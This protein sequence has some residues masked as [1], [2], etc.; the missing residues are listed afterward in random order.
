[1]T[2]TYTS[3]DGKE[4]QIL[5]N[6][7]NTK[8]GNFK[9]VC[10]SACLGYFGITPDQYRYTSSL[11]GG[12]VNPILGIYRRFG[13]AVRSRKSNLIKGS[14]SVGAVRKA[15]KGYT[16]YTDDVKYLVHVKGHVLLLDSNGDTIVDTAPRQVD[17][18]R[19]YN[20]WAIFKS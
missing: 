13:W 9:G 20:V 16:D 11:R 8:G 1:M 5:S 18:R 4:F 19:V 14:K 3:K 2:R 12:P 15:I 7:V 10:V 6:H 17:R